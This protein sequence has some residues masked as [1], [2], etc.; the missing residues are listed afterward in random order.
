MYQEE[1]AGSAGLG[2]ASRREAA[3]SSTA[4]AA[5]G[6]LPLSVATSTAHATA[7][8]TPRE[9]PASRGSCGSG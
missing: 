4:A 7:A 9:F 1:P 8:V 2:A 3:C 5:L 6:S